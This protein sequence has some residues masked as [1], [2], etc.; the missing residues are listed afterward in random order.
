MEKSPLTYALLLILVTCACASSVSTESN[1][2]PSNSTNKPTESQVSKIDDKKIS[3]LRDQIQQIASAAKGKVGVSAVVLENGKA[4]SLNPHDHFPMQSVYKLPIS[5]A[6]M[7]Q[8]DAGKLKL[9]EKV[10]VAKSDFFRRGQHNPI[11]D[12]Y[13]NG[14]ELSVGELVRFAISESD[15]TGSDLLLKLAGGAEAVQAYLKDLRVDGMVVADTEKEIGQDWQTQYQNWATPEA[16]VT[17]LRALHERRGLS[18]QSQ[19]LLLKHLIESRPGA[20]RL[21]GLL[22]TGTVVAHKTGTSGTQ[23]G[24]TAATNDIGIITLP[25]GNHLAIAVFVSDSS[26]EGK[27]REAVIARIAEVVFRDFERSN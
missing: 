15:S 5:M 23:N 17:L 1:N 24:I 14:V 20:N 25:N 27:T 10:H 19:A 18:E 16:A 21:K 4:V 2:P 9:D 22:P 26:A 8:V 6:V 7:Q 3:E 12:K 11:R 13:P